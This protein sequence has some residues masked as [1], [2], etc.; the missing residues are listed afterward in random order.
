MSELHELFEGEWKPMIAAQQ[1]KDFTVG[2][3]S[4]EVLKKLS[5]GKAF[6][7]I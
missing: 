7:K 5:E 3:N 4:S 6:K 1:D 2:L